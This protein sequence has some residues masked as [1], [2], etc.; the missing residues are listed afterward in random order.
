[1]RSTYDAFDVPVDGGDLRVGR[2]TATNPAAP[3]VVAVHGVTANHRAW[4][5]LGALNRFTL[6][7]VDLRGRGRSARLVGSS[8]MERHADDLLGVLDHLGLPAPL[9]VGHSMGGF[10]V[11]A[12]LHRHAGR[13]SGA[14]LVDGG[15]PF[16]PLPE[17]VTTEQALNATIGPAAQRLTMEFPTPGD[18]LDFWR[19]HPAFAADW[20]P[21]VEDY[22]TYDLDGTRSSV[23]LDAVREDS[24]GLLDADGAPQWAA[25]LPSGTIFLRAPRGMLDDPGGLYPLELVEQHR[26]RFPQVDVRDVPDTNHYTVVMSERGALAVADALDAVRS[27][28]GPRA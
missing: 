19:P 11:S 20:G 8:G 15:L 7:A 2:W 5:F 13:G 9:L 1:V 14:L 23:S 24:S 17:G 25:S 10:V 28:A 12:F 18:Y 3:V 22:L 16:P 6:V 26:S 27:A 21:E 4:Q